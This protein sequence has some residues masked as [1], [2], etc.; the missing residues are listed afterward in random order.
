M[1]SGSLLKFASFTYALSADPT[2]LRS[3]CDVSSRDCRALCPIHERARAGKIPCT[4]IWTGSM[5]TREGSFC[6]FSDSSLAVTT[7]RQQGA[8]II[9]CLALTSPN[10][11]WE[12]LVSRLEMAESCASTCHVSTSVGWGLCPSL[13]CVKTVNAV[14][15]VGNPLHPRGT[16]PMPISDN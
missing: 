16:A 5:Q 2:T 6:S 12:A 10:I 9:S 15:S 7:W 11:F 13:P 3:C 8:K 1:D 14:C 4:G